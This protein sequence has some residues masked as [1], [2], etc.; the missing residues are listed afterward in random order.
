MPDTPWQFSGSPLRPSRLKAPRPA[1]AAGVWAG[2]AATKPH[3]AAYDPHVTCYQNRPAESLKDVIQKLDFTSNSVFRCWLR[4][5]C[6]TCS[7]SRNAIG[8]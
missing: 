7:Q 3:H 1:V 8:P 6:K 4:A 2:R 5:V